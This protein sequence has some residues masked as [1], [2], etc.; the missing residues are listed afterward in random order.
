MK[1]NKVTLKSA[2]ISLLLGAAIILFWRG[3]WDLADTYLYPS[4]VVVS[5]VLSI[6][7]GI[8]ILYAFSFNLRGL[9]P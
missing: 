5:A 4:D 9:R 6:L 2:I 7:I 8:G 1:K 3:I